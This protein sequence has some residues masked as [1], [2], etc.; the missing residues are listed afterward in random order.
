MLRGMP[1]MSGPT[2]PTLSTRASMRRWPAAI[3]CSSAFESGDLEAPLLLVGKKGGRNRCL[4]KPLLRSTVSG[5]QRKFA[6]Y[7]GASSGMDSVL[8]WVFR[9]QGWGLWD[10]GQRAVRKHLFPQ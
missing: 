2:V 5:D 1:S 3:A 7:M 10:G 6:E 4:E 9:P 8:F